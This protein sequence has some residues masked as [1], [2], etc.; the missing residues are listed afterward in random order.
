MDDPSYDSFLE[1]IANLRLVSGTLS[2]PWKKDEKAIL[3]LAIRLVK[4]K[5]TLC[6]QITEHYQ[7]KALHRNLSPESCVKLVQDVIPDY[8]RQGIFTTQST[9]YHLLVSKQKELKII[10]KTSEVAALPVLHNRKKTYILEEGVPIPF[11]ISLGVMNEQGKVI[12]K[13]YD[14]FRQINRFVE[15]VA[16]LIDELP[17]NACLE[18]IDFGCGKA[19]L[20]FALH[21]Y[22]HHILKRS[23][24][25]VGLDLKEDVIHYCQNLADELACVGLKFKVGDIKGFQP[26]KKVNLVISLHACDTATDAALE[27]AVRWDAD[28]ILCVPCC[29]HELFSQVSCDPLSSLLRHGLLKERFAALATDA[30]RAELLTVLGYDVQVLEFID[31]EHTP[32][33]ILLRAVKRP[34][35]IRQEQAAKR[36]SSFKNTLQIAPSLEKMF[37]DSIDL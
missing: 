33:N 34:Q 12:P 32:K 15:M 17:K 1:E 36:Y 23:V 27:K 19:Y 3:R 26:E 28:V 8:F 37:T 29:Q 35:K 18:V 16:D 21:Y 20:T 5:G 30:A 6:Y 13:K 31:M 10:K 4:I 25:M 22:L 7:N 11:L 24:N 14:K 2:S 9:H